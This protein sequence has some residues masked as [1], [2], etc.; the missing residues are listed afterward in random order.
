MTL[1]NLTLQN[2][3]STGNGGAIADDGT[4]TVTDST[5]AGNTASGTGGAIYDPGTAVLTGDTFTGNSASNDFGGGAVYVED[6]NSA[7]IS[8]ST[9]S[10]NSAYEAGAVSLV[11]AGSS[12]TVTNSTFVGNISTG[13]RY[14]G[15]GAFTNAGSLTVTNATFS[16]NSAPGG[17]G[18]A[19][20]SEGFTSTHL[21]LAG[22]IFAGS[23]AGGNCVIRSGFTDGGYNL[24]D[25]G[26]CLNGGSGDING[27]DPKLDPNGLQNNG[28]PTQ[29]S[30][31]SR[32][33]RPSDR[34]RPRPPLPTLSRPPLRP[35]APLSISVGTSPYLPV[36]HRRL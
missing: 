6:N 32:A 20:D 27:Q 28:G 17:S 36:R 13:G 31:S 30:P 4:L 11:N 16:G 14:G 24:S 35:Y 18:A 1:K 5:F 21:T 29:P 26:S 10:N 19:I 9:F 3:S 15:G 12:A 7:T 8:G 34:S 22:T 33:A 25:D 23:V 2:G